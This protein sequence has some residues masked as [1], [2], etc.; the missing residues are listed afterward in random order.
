[1]KHTSFPLRLVTLALLAL[2]VASAP[3]SEAF[4]HVVQKGDTLAAIAER[5]Y[6][7][8]QHE[9]LLVAAN[10]LDI[11][12]GS[13]IVPGM[14]LEVPALGHY[15]VRPGDTWAKL[16]A[17]LLGAP[18]RADVLSIANGSSPWKL[19]EE[20]AELIVP[21]NLRV[22]VAT[23]DNIVNIAYRF[24]GDR[25]KAWVLDHY[26]Q[27]KGKKLERGDVVL[28]PITDLQLTEQGKLAAHAAAERLSS[29]AAGQAREVQRQVANELPALLADVRG[30]RYVS[31]V[32][33]GND[34]LSR[35]TLS[36]SELGTIYRSLVE[37]YVALNASGLAREACVEWRRHD[38]KARLDPVRLSPK[39]IQA[40]R[41]AP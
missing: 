18:H 5:F 13:G 39:I 32:A 11:E 16:A 10:A 28:V 36:R 35:G 9:R 34:F 30:G 23:N 14:L 24:W 1:M 27:L 19:T 22:I 8:I 17:A 20:G 29:E 4:V 38:A 26:N 25:N 6:G 3:R 37:A 33:R 31:A 21:Y 2:L 12:G 7:R 40:C 15:R 41:A